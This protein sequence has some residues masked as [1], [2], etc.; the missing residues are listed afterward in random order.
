MVSKLFVLEKPFLLNLLFSQSIANTG[1]LFRNVKTESWNR[2][3]MLISMY[4]NNAPHSK[5]D[6]VMIFQSASG[7]K[8][9]EIT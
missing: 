7:L 8:C 2:S 3:V 5:G 6:K 1:V 9:V 4:L